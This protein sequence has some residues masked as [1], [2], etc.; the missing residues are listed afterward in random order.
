MNQLGTNMI[1]SYLH[2]LGVVKPDSA[3][4]S[5]LLMLHAAHQRAIPFENIDVFTG[6]P[7]S[8]DQDALFDKIVK[9]RRGGFCYELN[10]L[11]SRLLNA[12]GY[13]VR[14]MSAGVFNAEGV[15]GP[16]FDHLCLRVETGEGPYL[17]DVGFGRAPLHPIPLA[18]SGRIEDPVGV[19]RLR[20][21]ASARD[22]F[23]PPHWS[24]D[25]VSSDRERRAENGWM[26]L[27]LFDSA[28]R[29]IEDFLP[30]CGWHQNSPEAMFPRTLIVTRATRDG[31][32][33]V[34]GH[35]WTRTV[36]GETTRGEFTSDA[37]RRAMIRA[38]FEL[39]VREP[40]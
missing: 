17:C 15:V 28:E 31:R 32:I 40:D 4:R 16:A 13:P 29:E 6:I 19:F 7:L 10:F 30:Q 37:D 2:R 12:L 5:A 35:Q 18:A 11:F 21:H 23:G 27:Y 25:R 9:R 33:S 26:P 20:E 3:N 34:R 22:G 39:D 14:L 24:L 1:E 36:D 8:L 38:E